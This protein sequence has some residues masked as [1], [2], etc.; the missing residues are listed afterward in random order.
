MPITKRLKRGVACAAILALTLAGCMAI[1]I[2]AQAASIRPAPPADNQS[3]SA[4]HRQNGTG[5]GVS[6]SAT[7][8]LVNQVNTTFDISK[9]SSPASLGLILG[10]AA[11]QLTDSIIVTPH[12]STSLLGGVQGSVRVTN[13]GGADTQG[14]AI[15]VIVLAQGRW[16]MFRTVK[17]Q[18]VDVSGQPVIPAHGQA[19]YSY[20]V[21]FPPVDGAYTY[22]VIARV[23][24]T[25]HSGHLGRAFGPSPSHGFRL[26]K[27][28]T[29]TV[30]SPAQV[31]LADSQTVP[32]GL[33]VNTASASLNGVALADLAGPWTL[34]APFA[35]SYDLEIAK[36][37]TPTAAGTFDL[38]DVASVAGKSATAHVTVR[39]TA[40]SMAGTVY[41]DLNGNGLADAGEPG[42]GGVTVTLEQAGVPLA[43][44][45]TDTNGRYLFSA[46]APGEYTVTH[47]PP[48]FAQPTGSV[49]LPVTLPAGTQITGVD[50]FDAYSASLA[51]AV[52]NDLN[53]NGVSDP[54]EVGIS[55]VEVQVWSGDVLLA[56]T[57]TDAIG[58][59]ML[60]VLIPGTYTLKQ[61]VPSGLTSTGPASIVRAVKSGDALSGLDF[62]D[63]ASLQSRNVSVKSG[64]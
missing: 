57:Y 5:I 34:S 41:N 38:A 4:W 12:S 37:V 28:P 29:G 1:V 3:A 44:L 33:T 55:D 30:Y 11:G 24:I 62:F 47:V 36:S 40:A 53:G 49:S 42:I 19:S 46:L 10:G 2:P 63:M 16:G 14:L 60:T 21:N 39:V 18:P 26:P 22:K 20:S 8:T 48:D 52:I 13:G 27:H 6:V 25:N 51:G 50:F 61:V 59:Y 17:S 32:E 43:S 7:G 54:G 58:N 35:A 23:T 45:A 9:T 31:S 15:Q 64:K 56:A